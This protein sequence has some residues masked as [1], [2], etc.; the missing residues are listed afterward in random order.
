MGDGPG[1]SAKELLKPVFERQIKE[2][3]RGHQ[4]P[5]PALFRCALPAILTFLVIDR[6]RN[7]SWQSQS[8][9]PKGSGCGCN[10]EQLPRL[11]GGH[12]GEGFQRDDIALPLLQEHLELL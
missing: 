1:G 10:R 3:P 4:T 9:L 2:L 11:F 6:K 8:G 12:P 5:F 7:G